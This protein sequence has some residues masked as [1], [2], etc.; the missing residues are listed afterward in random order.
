MAVPHNCLTRLTSRTQRA[1]CVASKSWMKST[2][3]SFLTTA[4]FIRTFGSQSHENA[5]QKSPENLNALNYGKYIEHTERRCPAQISGA[6]CHARCHRPA[7]GPC[8]SRAGQRWGRHW[9]L[10]CTHVRHQHTEAHTARGK[11][12][13]EPNEV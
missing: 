13:P 11:G 1:S 12:R 10:A 9:R 5:D 3:N 6:F 8:V 2:L 7:S 4:C